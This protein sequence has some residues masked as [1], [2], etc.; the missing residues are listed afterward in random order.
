MEW[1]EKNVYNY[2]GEDDDYIEEHELQELDQLDALDYAAC[3][4]A[5]E[6]ASQQRAS[7]ARPDGRNWDTVL[8]DYGVSATGRES[9]TLSWE[10]DVR[11]ILTAKHSGY[12]CT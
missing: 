11:M 2:S 1:N 9:S 4:R 8:T 12:S 3:L 5:A 6:L 7:G 10:L